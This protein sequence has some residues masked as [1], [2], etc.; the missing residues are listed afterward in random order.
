MASPYLQVSKK[1][2]IKGGI[3]IQEVEVSKLVQWF[4]ELHHCLAPG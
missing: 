2:K 3:A 4:G 1:V